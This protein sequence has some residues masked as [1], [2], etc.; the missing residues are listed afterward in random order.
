[1]TSTTNSVDLLAFALSEQRMVMTDQTGSVTVELTADGSIT[2]IRLSHAGQRMTPAMVAELIMSLHSA[3]LAQAQKAIEATLSDGEVPTIPELNHA[4]TSEPPTSATPATAGPN[5]IVPTV[6]PSLRHASEPAP[7]S[8]PPASAPAERMVEQ[9]ARD[10]ALTPPIP[11]VGGVAHT[12]HAAISAPPPT[13]RPRPAPAPEY[14]D[15][16]GDEDEYFRTLSVFE[17]DDHNP[18]H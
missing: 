17:F 11:S 4:D 3:G 13:P 9:P 6:F 14:T 16:P 8:P 12:T 1:M 15:D 2:G 5:P 7:P 18:R 10:M